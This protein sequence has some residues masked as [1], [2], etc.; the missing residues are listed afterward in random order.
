[1]PLFYK[2]FLLES[3]FLYKTLPMRIHNYR[4]IAKPKAI[5]P[6]WLS[7]GVALLAGLS[8]VLALAPYKVWGV[9][10]LS[11]LLL[12]ALLLT[13]MTHKRAFLVGWAYG[14]GVWLTGAF[15]LYTSI[16]EYGGIGAVAAFLMIVVMACIMGLFH[17]VMAWAFVR[18]MGRQPLA[19]A[20]LWVLQEWA[21]T[22]V[23]TG[24]PWLFVGY[25]YTDMPFITALAPLTGVFGISF[26]SVLISASVVELY[27]KQ[28]GYLL[29]A[30]V[31]L[32][33][34]TLL[35]LINPAWTSPTG[36]KLSVS[37]VQGN[38]RQDIKWVQTFQDEILLT[39]ATLTQNE[40]GRDLIVWPEAAVPMFQ[41]EAADFLGQIDTIARQT[42]STLSTGI[43]YKALEE[44][45]PSHHAYPPFYNAVMTLGAD[46]GLYKKQRLVPFGEYI[47]FGGV[48]DILPNLATHQVLSHSRGDDHQTPTLVQH[49]NMGVAICYEV[50]YPDTI[51]KNAQDTHFLMT[52]SND[53]WFGTSAG[54]HQHLQMVQMRSL[55]T[56]R[57]TARST[58]TGIT[59]IIDDKGRIVQSMPQ[60]TK[61]V[62]RGKMAMMTGSTPFMR[63]GYYPI[64][65]GL[66]VL[67]LLSAWAGKRE[68][69]F[70]KD[71]KY[72]QD[73]R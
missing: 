50:A 1:M 28:A 20:S 43:P 51:R 48:L 19:F 60:F 8:F 38:I 5:L 42:G 18:F 6:I 41:D 32:G 33:I 66:I 59:A 53:A 40:W 35:W 10:L 70:H 64:L 67:L 54:P 45:D 52:V 34:S 65:L 39:Y 9:A 56:G 30:G 47:P 61:G 15:W 23:L 37:L 57:W 26:L 55:E 68:L 73:Y 69:Y 3:C 46:K 12:Y 25:A 4:P 71:G 72:L 62:L 24:F 7:V 11:P 49:K 16:H 22:W 17:A 2:I 36:D 63:F 27:R 21:K 44:Y 14:F 58:N 29:I 13:S 31:L